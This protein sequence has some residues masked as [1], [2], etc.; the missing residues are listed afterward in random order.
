MPHIIERGAD[1]FKSIGT[2]KSYGPKLYC[3]SGHVNK[4]VCVELP[5]G[6]TCRALIDE[7]AGGVWKGRKAKAAVPG[8][9]SMGLLSADELDTPLD[10]ES[11]RKPG[12]LGLGTAAVTVIDDQT[13]IV[14]YLYNTCRFFAH[15]S[16][17][18]CTPCREG[19]GWFYKTM[20]RIKAGGGRLEDLDIMLQLANNMGIIPGTTI[21]GL[22]DG[23]AWPIKNAIAKFRGELED[24]IRTHQTPTARGHAA[25]GDDRPRRRPPSDPRRPAHRPAGSAARAPAS[26]DR[27]RASDSTVNPIEPGRT[28]MA[29]II[30]NGNEY[31]IPEG[32]K[33]NAIQMAQRVGID[34]PYYCWHPALSVVANCR[35]C[36]IEVGT[37]DPKTGEIK[38]L[39][40]LVPGCQ[41][42]AKD[43]TVLVTDSPKVKEHQRMIMEY[44]L[45]NHPLDC[46]VCDQAGECGLQDY[47]FRY[48]QAVHR[49]VEERTVNP[50][51]DVSDLIQLNMDRCIMCTRCVRFTREISQTGELQVMRR[52]NHAEIDIFPGQPV[53]NPLAGNVVDLCPVGALL[54]KDFLHKQR[55][56]FLS[57]HDC[58]LHALLDRAATSAPRRTAGRSGGSSPGHNPARQRLLDLR[59]G[60]VQ[61][62]GGQRPQPAGGD[63]RPQERRPPAGRRSTRPLKAV[64]QGLKE[65]APAGGIVAG[66]LSPFLTVEEAYLLAR[67][68]KGLSPANVL[69]LG[70]VPTRGAD[71]TFQPDQTKGRTGDT[72]FVVP[73]PF[74]IHAEKCPNRRGVEPR[75]SSTSRARSSAST[76]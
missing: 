70:P 72:S 3:V 58:D 38:M 60:P 25:P 54:D 22:A 5:L 74:T 8:G 31:P 1:W 18:Q 62:Q 19:T 2:P 44:L 12:C 59:R 16:C 39:P 9:I 33:L 30:I 35:M 51:K 21:C 36:E 32:E 48:G 55:A 29:T 41:T 23:A 52:G 75:S 37:K 17:G 47:S 49:F 4:Q 45:L 28:P 67:Y 10:F 24:Y 34:I 7:H 50:R 71:Q 73:R 40:K 76:S 46:P 61:L 65:I 42:P 63:V 27:G 6:I 26:S 53:D 20:K 15:E 64:D 57:K 56:W 66:V 11:L 68:L 69:A 14:D 43:L 13:S